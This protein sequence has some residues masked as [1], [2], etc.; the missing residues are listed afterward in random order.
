[1]HEHLNLAA[2]CVSIDSVKTFKNLFVENVF[3]RILIVDGKERA[4][5]VALVLIDFEDDPRCH[6]SHF[7]GV[8][9]K[10]RHTELRANTVNKVL[11]RSGRRN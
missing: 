5:S 10:S 9:F 1:M 7:F 6:F 8:V 3:P 11:E 2:I 4:D